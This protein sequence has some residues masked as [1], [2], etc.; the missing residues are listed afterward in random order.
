MN[1][2]E[3]QAAMASGQYFTVSLWRITLA[4]TGFAA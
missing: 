2:Y 1:K 3:R 4:N